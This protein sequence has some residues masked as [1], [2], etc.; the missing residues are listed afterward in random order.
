MEM[1]ASILIG[2][3]I[4]RDVLHHRD[5]NH[6]DLEIFSFSVDLRFGGDLGSRG[7]RVIAERLLGNSLRS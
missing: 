5:K 7:A 3:A 1:S 6:L 2:L 4:E